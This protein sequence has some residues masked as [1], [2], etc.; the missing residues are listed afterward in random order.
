MQEMAVEK[1]V[2]NTNYTKRNE[3]KDD[4]YKKR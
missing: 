3:K 4:I 1:Y 2:D